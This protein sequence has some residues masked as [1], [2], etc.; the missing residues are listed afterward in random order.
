MEE[1]KKTSKKK[2]KKGGIINRLFNGH[3]LRDERITKNFGL[4]ALITVYMVLYVSNRYAFQQEL[5][6]ISNLKKEVKTL[7]YDVLIQQSELSEKGRQSH[8]EKY[9]KES[10][11]E[12]GIATQPPF[13]IK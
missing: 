6:T 9:V 10:E 3:L 8:I 1:A 12:L 4:F 7:E 11:S 13:L 5:H 2:K